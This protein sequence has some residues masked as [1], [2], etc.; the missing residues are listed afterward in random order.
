MFS[1]IRQS[2]LEGWKVTSL[3]V[4]FKLGSSLGGRFKMEAECLWHQTANRYPGFSTRGGGPWWEFDQCVLPFCR[5]YLLRVCIGVCVSGHTSDKPCWDRIAN[6]R[7]RI[8]RLRGAGSGAWKKAYGF[9]Y[10]DTDTHIYMHR[11]TDTLTLLHSFKFIH[12]WS[13]PDSV[14]VQE[15]GSFLR[16]YFGRVGDIWC[17][18]AVQARLSWCAHVLCVCVYTCMFVSLSLSGDGE[19]LQR[20]CVLLGRMRTHFPPT[21]TCVCAYISTQ[22][23]SDGEED[24]VIV[25]PPQDIPPQGSDDIIS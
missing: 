8:A 17:D 11:Y 25:K 1:L 20:C 2:I 21:L 19:R 18:A 6:W 23:W 9:T 7:I 12:H 15:C 10:R 5:C 3:A 13:L 16:F 4:T 22:V 14:F 24:V